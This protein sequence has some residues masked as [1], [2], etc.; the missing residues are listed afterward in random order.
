MREPS[1]PTR[2]RG[3][4][5][6]HSGIPRR[7]VIVTAIFALTPIPTIAQQAWKLLTPEEIARDGAAPQVP[8]PPD[9]P[10]PP[11]ID[12]VRPDIS[13]PIRNPATIELR[14]TPGPGQSIDMQS[15]NATYGRLGIDITRR[16]LAHATVKPNGLWAEGVE[17]PVGNH[18]V[19]ISI[20]HTS[21]KT[22]SRTFRFSVA[23]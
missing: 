2:S 20:A 6:N 12:L 13:R 3:R 22:A 10:P 4:A 8:V 5:M 11:T 15:F 18:R 7:G 23:S 19:T 16:L 17:L 9:L 1:M 14:F 21:G